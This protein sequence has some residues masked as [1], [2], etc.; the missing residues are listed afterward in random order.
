MEFKPVMV[1]GLNTSLGWK[2]EEVP[3]CKESHGEDRP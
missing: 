3:D 2:Q 1:L